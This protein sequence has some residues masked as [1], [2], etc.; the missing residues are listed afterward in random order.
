MRRNV[1]R[2][3]KKCPV[4]L[5]NVYAT[6]TFS[7]TFSLRLPASSEAGE[8]F[9]GKRTLSCIRLHSCETFSRS[10][11]ALL[12]RYKV[13]LCAKAT[14]SEFLCAAKLSSQSEYAVRFVYHPINGFR[15]CF[16]QNALLYSELCAVRES[17]SPIAQTRL[18]LCALGQMPAR[19]QRHIRYQRT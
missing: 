6:E 18:R 7:K 19:F 15:F 5:E 13:T 9:V 1:F 17:R 4:A 3:T 2:H 16:I 14:I 11:D 10:V 8:R 12:R